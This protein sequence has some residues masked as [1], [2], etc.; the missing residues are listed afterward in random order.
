MANIIAQ[1][2]APSWF[3]VL[4]SAA[5]TA[6]PVDTNE[7]E[8]GGRARCLTVVI[9]VTAVTSTPSTTFKIQGVDR[10][11]GKTWDILA[12]AAIAATG[13][14]IMRVGPGIAVT[15]NVSANDVVP[16][17]VRI[18]ASHGNANSM[19][20]SIAGLVSC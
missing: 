15:A 6:T 9:D 14:V 2:S 17:I 20:Y 3:A 16:P 11:S 13:T 1:A 19:T 18:V 7:Y 4:P 12:S 10:L 5:R 8:L